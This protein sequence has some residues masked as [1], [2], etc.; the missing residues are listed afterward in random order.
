MVLQNYQH[1]IE[2]TSNMIYI[3]ALCGGLKCP[4]KINLNTQCSLR[5]RMLCIALQPSQ[6][7]GIILVKWF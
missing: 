5:P 6:K 1:F 3:V 4:H 2:M 7:L